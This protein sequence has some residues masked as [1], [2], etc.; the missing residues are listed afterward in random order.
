MFDARGADRYRGENEKLDPVGGHIPGAISAPYAG[1]LDA[2]GYFLPADALRERWKGLLQDTPAEQAVM[3]C[4]SGVTAVHNLIALEIA[5]LGL[6]KLYP[7]SWSDW[8]TDPARPIA[9][10]AERG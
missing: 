7:G 1:N 8:I 9:T 2:I 6:G 4:G 5:G 10:G 3:Y